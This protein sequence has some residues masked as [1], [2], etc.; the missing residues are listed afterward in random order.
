MAVIR[1]DA[2][3][4]DVA[5]AARPERIVSLVPSITET[6]FALGLDDRIAGITL[7]CVE[8]RARVGAKPKVGREKD[9]DVERIL[10]L[11]P[12][13][14]VANIEENRRDVVER[15]REAGIPVWVV[16]PRTLRE[17]IRMIRELGDVTGAAGEADRLA[18]APRGPVR[19]DGGRQRGAAGRPGLLPDLARPV[20]DDQPRHLRPR[21]PRDVRGAERLRRPSR[22][23]PHRD[24]RRGASRR[25]R[26]HPAPRRAATTSARR[27]W[28]TSRRSP[29]SRRWR[30]GGAA[31]W[32]GSCSPGTARGSARRSTRLPAA[33]SPHRLASED[34]LDLDRH[35]TRRAPRRRPGSR[36]ARAARHRGTRAARGPGR[37]RRGPAA[38]GPSAA[39]TKQARTAQRR[40]RASEPSAAAAAA[41][42]LRVARRI[43]ARAWGRLTSRPTRPR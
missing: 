28:R 5:L 25:S 24:P 39:S 40:A 4:A 31:S 6:L 33:C 38:T 32:T 14:V 23:L 43:A 1:R 18:T 20:H 22:P 37:W 30:A 7:F 3:G 17:G 13:L 42:P 35:A 8:P 26:G 16:F 19:G 9:P 41:R 12:D 27:T 11:A 29:T 34:Q 10:A 2:S 15:L 36:G 21:R